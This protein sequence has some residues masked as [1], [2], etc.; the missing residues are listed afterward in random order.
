MCFVLPLLI[1]LMTF[2][3][4]AATSVMGYMNQMSAANAQQAYQ[5]QLRDQQRKLADLETQK[6]LQ[7]A[8]A[9]RFKEAQEKEQQG[10]D[11]FNIT[12]EAK[13]ARSRAVVSAGEAGVSGA[14]VDAILAD[15]T[16]QETT[17]AQAVRRQGFYT[18]AATNRSIENARLGTQ[19]NVTALQSPMPPIQKPNLWATALTIGQSGL[20]AYGQYMRYSPGKSPLASV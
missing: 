5:N 17:Y 19:Y 20:D 15:F 18:E 14:S 3:I 2:A 9:M 13:A 4:G 11:I 12:Q 6:Y 8:E 10:R 7:E 1:P 16:R